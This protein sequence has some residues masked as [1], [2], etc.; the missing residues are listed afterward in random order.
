MR[1]KLIGAVMG[2][3][4]AFFAQGE[5]S[6]V[7][8][9]EALYATSNLWG[10]ADDVGAYRMARRRIGMQLKERRDGNAIWREWN[11]EFLRFIA[12]SPDTSDVWL[13]EG[14]VELLMSGS[15]GSTCTSTNCW[16]A[17]AD[18]SRRVLGLRRAAY[19]E[20]VAQNQGRGASGT[21]EL[22][23]APAYR[24]AWNRLAVA[25]RAVEPAL[26]ALTN[27]FPAAILPKLSTDEGSAFYSNVLRRA[28]LCP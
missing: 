6:A 27:L 19:A 5:E 15:D 24:E 8:L 22:G 13:E 20:W 12:H 9:R 11:E 18:Y 28:D 25:D 2:A 7:A 4:V 10:R 1:G 16:L 3:I 23:T 26:Y 21:F 17:A 14:G